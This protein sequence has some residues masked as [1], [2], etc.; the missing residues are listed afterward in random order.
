[1]ISCHGVTCD[2]WQQKRQSIVAV[3]L[4]CVTCL[5]DLLSGQ[6]TEDGLHVIAFLK[7]NDSVLQWSV[8]LVIYFWNFTWF[9]SISTVRNPE[10]ENLIGQLR[11]DVIMVPTP[12][13]RPQTSPGR[14]PSN[15][16]YGPGPYSRPR[17]SFSRYEPSA[18]KW[19][20]SLSTA[21]IHEAEVDNVYKKAKI[22]QSHSS[23]EKR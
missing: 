20:K 3:L 13:Y 1:M 21:I 11:Q 2:L 19:H 4:C 18:G 22:L 14:W 6:V 16:R 23:K 12:T 9:S 8:T 17:L 10:S 15:G 7:A 5:A